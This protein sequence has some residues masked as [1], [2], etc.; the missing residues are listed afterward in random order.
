MSNDIFN[1]YH[2][3]SDLKHEA[4][5]IINNYSGKKGI[6]QHE[7]GDIELKL[8]KE[9]PDDHQIVIIGRKYGPILRERAIQSLMDAFAKA[10]GKYED[11]SFRNACGES[12]FESDKALSVGWD[13]ERIFYLADIALNEQKKPAKPKKWELKNY[14]DDDS[15]VECRYFPTKKEALAFAEKEG[16]TDTQVVPVYD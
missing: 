3:F 15:T 12:Y 10:G 11:D 7:N 14:W 16:Y 2:K 1:Y 6:I 13:A 4:V 5:N 9:D 8:V